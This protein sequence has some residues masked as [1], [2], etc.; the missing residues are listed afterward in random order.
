M[1]QHDMF[2]EDMLWPVDLKR[3][4]CCEARALRNENK[5]LQHQWAELM[6]ACKVNHDLADHVYDV[7]KAAVWEKQSNDL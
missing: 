5:R 3:P 1:S 6:S 2:C 4:C 7:F